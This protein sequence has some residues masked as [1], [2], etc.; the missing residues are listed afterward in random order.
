MIPKLIKYVYDNRES[1]SVTFSTLVERVIQQLVRRSPTATHRNKP[2][3]MSWHSN[4]TFLCYSV[5]TSALT[6][7]VQRL[8]PLRVDVIIAFSTI[9]H[10]QGLLSCVC[11]CVSTDNCHWLTF[12]C[13]N[14]WHFNGKVA[15]FISSTNT[16]RKSLKKLVW[17]DIHVMMVEQVGLLVDGLVN[18]D[19][20]E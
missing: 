1:E 7:S 15:I 11:V 8:Y 14:I 12:K 13:S 19:L 18:T 6:F 20:F 10:H 17:G 3:L 5:I 4:E 9:T 2:N 16:E